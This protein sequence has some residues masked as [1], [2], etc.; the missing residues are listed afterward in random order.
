MC[1]VTWPPPHLHL[2]LMAFVA[3]LVLACLKALNILGKR[4]SSFTAVFKT[5]LNEACDSKWHCQ[6]YKGEYT[7][8][9]MY[10]RVSLIIELDL[11][12][13]FNISFIQK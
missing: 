5:E 10:E 8:C 6:N 3:I 11:D 12:V 4:S 1:L 13:C 2:D 9:V 7:F